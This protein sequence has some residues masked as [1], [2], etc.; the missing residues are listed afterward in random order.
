MPSRRPRRGWL[1]GAQ[2]ADGSEPLAPCSAAPKTGAVPNALSKEAARNPSVYTG[3]ARDPV[4]IRAGH[5]L[6]EGVARPQCGSVLA[7]KWCDL[8]AGGSQVR[9]LK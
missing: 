1:C 9:V 6:A 5:R 7:L 4:P 2:E 3:P 8:P